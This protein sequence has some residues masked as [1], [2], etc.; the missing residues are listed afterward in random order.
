MKYLMA[1]T[2]LA[3]L[4]GGAA[5]ANAGIISTLSATYSS[6]F[7]NTSFT[8]TNTSGVTETDIKISTSLAGSALSPNPIDLGSLAPGA[9]LV[10]S[11][12]N[13]D[14]GFVVD[15]FDSGLPDTT[16]YQYSVGFGGET[17]TSQVFDPLANLTGGDVDFLGNACQGFAQGCPVATSG[18]V[19]DVAVPEPRPLAVLTA[20]LPVL[21]LLRNRAARSRAAIAPRGQ[22]AT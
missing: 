9:S 10:Y 7:N 12:A 6:V 18:I 17:L 13:A 2:A 20:V 19:A 11:F 22:A 8:I 1:T 4:I 14:G 3:A 16:T 21:W 5:P 15:P